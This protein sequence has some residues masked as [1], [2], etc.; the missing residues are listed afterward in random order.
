MILGLYDYLHTHNCKTCKSIIMFYSGKMK[1]K[2]LISRTNSDVD[3][4]L[5]QTSLVLF[6]DNVKTLTPCGISLATL[7]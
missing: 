7:L 4:I 6:L 5:E 1:I 3:M 2:H